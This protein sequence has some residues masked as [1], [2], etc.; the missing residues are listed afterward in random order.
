MTDF[1]KIGD[2]VPDFELE[3]YEPR[4]GEFG[5]VSLDQLKKERK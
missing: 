1:L 3:T 5:T 2:L 4:A